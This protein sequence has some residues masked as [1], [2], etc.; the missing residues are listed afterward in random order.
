MTYKQ[1][2]QELM[3][4]MEKQ[5]WTV[6]RWNAS[7]CKPM[8]VP[9][10]TDPTGENRFYFKPRSIHAVRSEQAGVKTGLKMKYARSIHV[11]PKLL[12]WRISNGPK[13][14]G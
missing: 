7:T 6:V 8:K 12:L 2:I 4:H 3:N 10:A 14:E 11:D 5:G 13:K 1:T 9:H